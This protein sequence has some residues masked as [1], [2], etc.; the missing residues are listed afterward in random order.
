MKTKLQVQFMR[1]L[2]SLTTAAITLAFSAVT[3]NA[4]ALPDSALI[5]NLSKAAISVIRKASGVTFE[6]TANDFVHTENTK[7]IGTD[8]NELL[9]KGISFSNDIVAYSPNPDMNHH[10]EN[11]YK[12]LA[13]MGFNCVRFHISYTAFENDSL[14]FIYKQSGFDWLDQNIEWAK[15][16]DIGIIINMHVPQGGFQSFGEGTGLWTDISSQK[17][18]EML[19]TRLAMRYSDEPAVW[20]Y[21]LVN[22]PCLNELDTENYSTLINRLVKSIRNFAPYQMIFVERICSVV[23]ENGEMTYP[24]P[25]NAFPEIDDNNIVYEFHLY[26]PYFFTHQHTDWAGTYG[27]TMSYNSHEIIGGNYVS[28]TGF[29]EAEFRYNSDGWSYFESK[30]FTA[31]GDANVINAIAMVSGLGKDDSAYFDNISITEVSPDGSKEV[32]FYA[33][34]TNGIINSSTQTANANG[35]AEYYDGDGFKEKGCLKITGAEADFQQI[36]T[37]LE[38]RTGYQ[39]IISGY[40]KSDNGNIR[41]RMDRSVQCNYQV[42]NREYLEVCFEPYISLSEQR[43]V[44]LYLGEFGA[45]QGCFENEYG[46]IDWVHDMIDICRKN[47]IGFNYMCYSSQDFGLY[48][49]YPENLNQG[50]SELFKNDLM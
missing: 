28:W 6:H 8:G 1:K 29:T 26:E 35:K 7:I 24:L 19:W 30:P 12:N 23:N 31:N 16:Y 11:A 42:F 3:A 9:L 25:E 14:P 33:D 32:I 13:E 47:N 5:Q 15:K 18:L 21:G 36:F 4:T 43:N 37:A 40:A 22:E 45:V 44:P 20:G 46:G 2:F 50:L 27:R 39:Y 49:N 10:D 34:F 17:R 41:I 38:I 48:R